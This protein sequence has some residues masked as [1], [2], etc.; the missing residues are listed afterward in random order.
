MDGHTFL[1]G[2]PLKPVSVFQMNLEAF[3]AIINSIPE[4]GEKGCKFWPHRRD[5]D[6]YG[7]LWLNGRRENAAHRVSFRAFVGPIPHGFF[8]CHKCDNP[9]CV[10]PDHLFAGTHQENMADMVKKGRSNKCGRLWQKR[11][12]TA[13]PCIA[14]V[15]QI[16][17]GWPKFKRIIYFG[18][19]ID[20]V[21]GTDGWLS[22]VGNINILNPWTGTFF[23]HRKNCIKV[24]RFY[25]RH[26][27]FPGLNPN[28]YSPNEAR[29]LGLFRL[30]TS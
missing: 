23:K 3:K 9:P 17:D 24:T 26:G 1:S 19:I 22:N 29:R 4:T 12:A 7:I 11:K 27:F 28:P 10:N 5:Q 30:P 25:A 13:K 14:P 8:V 16:E 2:V 20:I 6:G 21:R 15:G 18:K